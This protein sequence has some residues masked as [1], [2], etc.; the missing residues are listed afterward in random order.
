MTGVL[1]DHR[2]IGSQ[3]LAVVILRSKHMSTALFLLIFPTVRFTL[4]N[5][6]KLFHARD[7]YLYCLA[8]LAEVIFFNEIRKT[9]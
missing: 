7:K 6:S 9:C 8:V 3:L 5:L 1:S 4:K 2:E